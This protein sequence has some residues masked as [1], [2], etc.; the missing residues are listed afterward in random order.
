MAL[1]GFLRGSNCSEEMK[2]ISRSQAMIWFS[3]SGTVLNANENFCKT[4]GYQLTEIVGQH[5]RMFCEEAIRSAPDYNAFWSDLA[6]GHFKSGQFRR[7]KKSGEDIW[8]E[9]TYNPVFRGSKVVRVL[10]IASDITTSRIQALNDGN[11]LRAIDQ[12]QAIIE[13]EPD[14]RV[15][16][17]NDNFLSAMGY[18]ADEV[19]GQFH[20]LFCDPAYVATSDYARFWDRLRAGEY[21]ADNFVRIGKGGRRVWIQAAYT[22][23]FNSRGL[24]YKVIK[25]ATDITARMQA[26]ETIGDAIGRL[27][28]G[29]LTVEIN[30]PIDTALERTRQDFNAAARALEA[31]VGSI[32]HSAEVLAANAAVIRSVSDD[33]ARNS[34]HQAASVEETAAAVEQIATTVRD[35]SVSAGQASQLVSATRQSAEASGKI[36][37][38]ATEAMGRIVTSSKEIENIISVI[39]E[40]AFQ[41]NLLA[42]NAGVEAARAGEAGKGFAVVAQEVRELAQRSAQAA[43][44]IK[45]LIAASAS[46]VEHGVTLVA[47]TGEALREIVRKV[48]DVDGNV[49]AISAAAREQSVGINEIN[50]AIG[51]LDK[52]SQK[53]ASTVEEANAAAQ[54]LAA[55][56]A[57]L[58][59]MIGRFKVSATSED[60]TAAHRRQVA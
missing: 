44:E 48:L 41:T 24:V 18:R 5:H 38:D 28:S 53:N 47:N 59:E 8:I 3:P 17:V 15:S 12:S 56:A 42:L 9:A 34:E 54:T 29:D 57:S 20:R 10:K 16:K 52:V 22:P 30:T 13:F 37:R 11:R 23:V 39:D 1:G 32:Q 50:A 2:A 60:M 31:T 6:A 27:A 40:I 4:L 7:Q 55:E 19:V 21:I 33:I 14:G 49:Q 36:V 35:S 51:S 26:V 43:K 45:A 58:Y 25:V 46:S